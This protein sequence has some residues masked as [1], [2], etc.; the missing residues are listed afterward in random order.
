MGSHI[1]HDQVRLDD[2]PA[3]A[4]SPSTSSASSLGDVVA[5][6]PISHVYRPASI[7]HR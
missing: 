1:Q 5:R 3:E 7:F 6:A 2:L 4:A